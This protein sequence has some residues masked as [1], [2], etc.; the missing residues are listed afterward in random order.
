MDG[1]EIVIAAEGE[2]VKRRYRVIRILATTVQVED[3]EG[4][5]TVTISI[6]EEGQN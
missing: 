6:T 2:M 3:T 5:R 4:K 1:D